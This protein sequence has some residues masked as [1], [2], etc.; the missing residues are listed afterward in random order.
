MVPEIV[1]SPTF[2]FHVL[3]SPVFGSGPFWISISPVFSILD[4]PIFS[5]P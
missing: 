4:E 5:P 2:E 1:N 3:A